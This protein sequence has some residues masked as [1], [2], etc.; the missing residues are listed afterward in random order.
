[1]IWKIILSQ[2][3]FYYV[4]KALSCKT[5]VELLQLQDLVTANAALATTTD[6][7][8]TVIMITYLQASKTGFK[9][10]SDMLN[11]LLRYSCR[12]SD[13]PLLYLGENMVRK[14]LVHFLVCTAGPLYVPSLDNFIG[15]RVLLLTIMTV[16]TNSIMV[17]LNARDYI[18]ERGSPSGRTEDTSN[19]F[20]S[21][22][23][24]A[25]LGTQHELNRTLQQQPAIAIQID[26][27]QEEH[28][29]PESEVV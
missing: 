20:Y 10:T 21:M 16:Y 6:L 19:S 22:T 15:S 23:R 12:H 28:P 4:V 18:Q 17:M 11:R 7:A 26:T 29:F 3:T 9:R 24:I 5:S 27:V 25:G 13:V 2:A 14:L 8:I 1:M